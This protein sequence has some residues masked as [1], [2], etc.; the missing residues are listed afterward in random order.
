M[1]SEE[2]SKSKAKRFLT[3]AE[4]FDLMSAL[5]ERLKSSD[6]SAVYGIPRGGLPIS[7]YLSHHLG[8][9]FI[10]S[11]HDLFKRGLKDKGPIIVV[12]D[13]VDTGLQMKS[14]MGFVECY[15]FEFI[16]ASLLVKPWSTFKPDFYIRKEEDWIVF[17]YEG[18]PE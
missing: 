14:T 12:D 4:Y 8:I 11:L 6:A 1:T 16:T 2:R 18:E 13:L 17:P 3:P 10:F 9:D 5:K 15:K 7:I